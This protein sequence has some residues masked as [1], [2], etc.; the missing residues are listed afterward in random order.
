MGTVVQ[1]LYQP[2]GGILNSE[3]GIRAHARAAQKHGAVLHTGEKM[4]RWHVL[5]SGKV[6]VITDKATYTAGRLVLTAGA[7]MPSPELVPELRVWVPCTVEHLLV[8]ICPGDCSLYVRYLLT[9]C[10]MLCSETKLREC[11]GGPGHHA[12]A[13]SGHWMV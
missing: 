2:Q 4:R 5:P 11:V 8:P 3:E 6:E 12:G 13:A 10:M 1:A 9:P 7:W